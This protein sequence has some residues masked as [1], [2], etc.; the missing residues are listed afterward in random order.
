MSDAIAPDLDI[1]EQLAR[2][3]YLMTETRKI[4]AEQTK[5]SEEAPKLRRT[6]SRVPFGE[7][8]LSPSTGQVCPL[9]RKACPLVRAAS[10]KSI[11]WTSYPVASGEQT[12]REYKYSF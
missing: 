4:S 7:R 10:E 3:D 12:N 5:L 11:T 2:I 8:A 9:V 1:R 6:P